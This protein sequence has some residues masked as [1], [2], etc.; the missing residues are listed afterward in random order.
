MIIDYWFLLLFLNAD[1][2]CLTFVSGF[3]K[4]GNFKDEII[5]SFE[6][7]CGILVGWLFHIGCYQFVV[8]AVAA[9]AVYGISGCIFG[10]FPLQE[11]VFPLKLAFSSCGAAATLCCGTLLIM[12]VWLAFVGNDILS[13]PI[14]LYFIVLPVVSFNIA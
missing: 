4:R 9:S 7:R 8:G 12:Y 11:T 10:G 3:V 2:S 6:F 5:G 14:D 1:C 13:L